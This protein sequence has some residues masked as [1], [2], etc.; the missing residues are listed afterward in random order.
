MSE[1]KT[2]GDPSGHVDHDDYY[3]P[4]NERGKPR[5]QWKFPEKLLPALER[6]ILEKY[7]NLSMDEV[8]RILR[9]KYISLS[10]QLDKDKD[11]KSL[12][13]RV[14]TFMG[15]SG[16]IEFIRFKGFDG[17]L[18]DMKKDYKKHYRS[19]LFALSCV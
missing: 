16:S 8:D 14:Q 12:H 3:L 11:N 19:I 7:G 1:I 18:K 10:A 6:D 15:A 9:M 2:I 4:E 13:S 5:K 17:N